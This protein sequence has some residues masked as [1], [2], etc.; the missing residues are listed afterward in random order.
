MRGQLGF[1][2]VDERLKRLSD[3]V[4]IWRRSKRWSISRFS[5]LI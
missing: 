1:F 2:D 3:L 4:I 5:A